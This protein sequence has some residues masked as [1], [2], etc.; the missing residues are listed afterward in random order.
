M[1]EMRPALYI[2]ALV[3]AGS[4]V[5]AQPVE[6]RMGVGPS[7]EE[8]AWLMKVRP[9][10]TPNQGKKYNYT[11]TMFRGGNERVLAFEGG[12]LDAATSSSTGILFPA[13]KGVKMV[14]V[15]RRSRAALSST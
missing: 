9:D 14:V 5:L 6:I 12:Q 15:A 3:L 1:I 13:T 10:L 11:M 2:C 4:S 8:P 7:S